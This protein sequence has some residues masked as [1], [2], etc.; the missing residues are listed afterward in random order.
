MGC[1]LK[2]ENREKPGAAR[3]QATNT[4]G[5]NET[6]WLC[7]GCRQI[8]HSEVREAGSP[9][10]ECESELLFDA[11]SPETRA[12]IDKAVASLPHITA[13]QRIREL[14]GCGLHKAIAVHTARRRAAD[15]NNRNSSGSIPRNAS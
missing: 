3:D 12:E 5:M 9:C 13:F 14:T 15:Q 2:L 7:R 6:S 4:G 10:F 8:I 1:S 11:Q